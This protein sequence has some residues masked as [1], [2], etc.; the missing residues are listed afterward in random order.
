MFNN[1]TAIDLT[2][3]IDEQ[4]P[5]SWPPHVPFVRRTWN[6]FEDTEQGPEAWTSHCGPYFTE[7]LIMDEHIATH[8]DAPSH[9]VHE[10]AP[11]QAEAITGEDVPVTAF[12]GNAVIVDAT[13]VP[14]DEPGVSPFVGPDHIEATEKQLGRQLTGDDIVL[15]RTDWDRKYYKP[16]AARSAYAHDVAVTGKSPG[17]P[18]PNPACAELLLARGVGC[19]G[20][21]APSMG[22]AHDGAPVHITGLGGGMVFIEGLANLAAVPEHGA[23]FQF[24]PIKIAR[25]SGGPGRAVAWVPR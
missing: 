25:S 11:G 2:L 14:G 16:G 20:T 19:F 9:F 13:G 22:A 8:F 18:A 17:W 5:T 3:L 7:V 10:H 4:Y 21:D 1:A 12:C 15:L 23:H 6:W 24:L